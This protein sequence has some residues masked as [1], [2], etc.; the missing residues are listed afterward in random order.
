LV[1]TRASSPVRASRFSLLL[2]FS[3]DSKKND[4]ARPGTLRHRP[5]L[6]LW[7]PACGATS[8]KVGRRPAVLLRG[9]PCRLC[10][11]AACGAA[12]GG[13]MHFP[14][15]PSSRACGGS[16]RIARHSPRRALSCCHPTPQI[17]SGRDELCRCG[18]VG[19]WGGRHRCGDHNTYPRRRFFCSSAPPSKAPRHTGTHRN[20]A[21]L[22]GLPY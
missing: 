11:H 16:A 5:G 22:A 20:A 3:R 14:A 18:P 15:S 10:R 13:P 19:H 7:R 21:A 8:H 17:F 9:R 1:Q 2:S 12:R 6:S 4:L